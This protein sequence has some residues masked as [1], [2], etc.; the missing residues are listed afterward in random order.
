MTRLLQALSLLLALIACAPAQAAQ[1][2]LENEQAF[3]F[4]ARLKDAGTIEVRY[5]I[6]PGY[7]MYRDHFRFAADGAKL[8]QPALP[9]GKKKFDETFK[10]TLETYRDNVVILLPFKGSAGPLTLKV[11]SQGCADIG[12]C[13][14]PIE[15]SAT[16]NVKS[17]ALDAPR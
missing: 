2:L 15:Q 1:D 16:L 11:T 7:Y 8:G 17:A 9:P 12:V 3:R 14:P 5:A 4:S 6:A 13:Y 10:Q